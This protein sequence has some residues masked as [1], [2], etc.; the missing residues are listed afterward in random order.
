VRTTPN[1][2][3][4]RIEGIVFD[5]DGTLIVSTIDFMQMRRQTFKRMKEAGV[6]EEILEEN[7]TIVANLLVS[8]NYLI[9][10]GSI[11]ASRSMCKDVGKIMSDIEMLKVG[12]TGAVPG[13]IQTIEQLLEEGYSIAVL[14][15]GSR[16]YTQAALEAAGLA[17]HLPC[18]VCRDD[19]P[20][21]EAKPNPI[22]MARAAR[23]MGLA[24]DRCI[25]VGD[26]PMDLECAR[27]A[28]SFFV[29]VLSGATDRSHWSEF[30]D[31]TVITDVSSLPALL[32]T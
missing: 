29:G 2:D 24:S 31:V 9:G 21:E 4:S 20:A 6:P 32:R 25:L 7:N 15:R 27:S 19:H 8:S 14:T 10:L 30:G 22:A 3:P 13:T 1:I 26:H 17:E 23:M 18:K 28:G 12:E 5:L 16:K 11:E